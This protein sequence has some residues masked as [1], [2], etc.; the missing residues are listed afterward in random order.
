MVPLLKPVPMGRMAC[1]VTVA[2][3]VKKNSLHCWLTPQAFVTA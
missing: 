3:G 2:L 1:S